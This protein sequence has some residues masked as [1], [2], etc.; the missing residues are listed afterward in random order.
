MIDKKEAI[1]RCGKALFA[2]KGFK[3]TSVAEIMQETGFATG[4]FYRFYPSKDHLFMEIYNQENVTLKKQILCK[5]DFSGSPMVIVREMLQRNMLGMKEDPIL[6]EWYN[7]DSFQKIE[8]NF[9]ETNA[10][11]KVDFLYDSFAEVVLGWQHD[12]RMRSDIDPD[13]IMA[14]FTALVSI[15]LHKDEI[16]IQY[17]PKLMEYISDFVMR[18]LEEGCKSDG[19]MHAL[20]P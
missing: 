11:E 6:R 9:R 18:G 20:D 10:L 3:D 4:T 15:D 12:G 17:F 19:G 8:N 7:R 1:F 14:I 5:L 16:G 13:M 2:A